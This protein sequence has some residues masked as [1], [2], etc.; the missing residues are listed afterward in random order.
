MGDLLIPRRM[1]RPAGLTLVAALFLLLATIVAVPTI[2]AWDTLIMQMCRQEFCLPLP[3]VCLYFATLSAIS[4]SLATFGL[5]ACRHWARRAALAAL[6]ATFGF[7]G[8]VFYL[9]LSA[10]ADRA[11]SRPAAPAHPLL[12]GRRVLHAVT[13]LHPLSP[14]HRRGLRVAVT[15]ANL[16]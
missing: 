13:R 16:R 6:A 12:R 11:A 9:Y 8:A 1:K 10:L 14:Y 3:I 7:F 5:F 4:L 2:V 15:P